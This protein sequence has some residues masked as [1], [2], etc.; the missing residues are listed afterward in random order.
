[1]PLHIRVAAKIVLWTVVAAALLRGA[2][3]LY[4]M[5]KDLR[6]AQGDIPKV[7]GWLGLLTP[8]TIV[9]LSIALGAS[10][11]ATIDGWWPVLRG[12]A[13]FAVQVAE[14]Q[15]DLRHEERLESRNDWERKRV[16][17]VYNHGASADVSAKIKISDD[18]RLFEQSYS[19]DYKPA[20]WRNDGGEFVRINEGDY[21]DIVCAEYL[22]D[23][24]VALLTRGRDGSS[25][26]TADTTDVDTARFAI[27]VLITSRPRN[28]SGS[29]SVR[30]LGDVA[31]ETRTPGLRLKKTGRRVVRI[32]N[33]VV[34]AT[35]DA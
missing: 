16:L 26:V 31:Y 2:V 30:I 1:M 32:G 11:V 7:W 14:S 9:L 27:D 28:V 18:G 10:A 13:G 21:A 20:V 6:D 23:I 33:E 15:A 17:R 8:E 19:R 25:V 4:G 3:D 35:P 24:Q 22:G 29:V 5:V 12:W 34:P